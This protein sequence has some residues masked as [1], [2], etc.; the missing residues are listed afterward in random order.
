MRTA[1]AIGA[2]A[3]R[4]SSP[5]PSAD[6]CY[7]HAL[8]SS[9]TPPVLVRLLWL[10]IV[11]LVEVAALEAG[12]RLQG[13]SEASPGFQS[14]FMDD[15]AVGHRLRPNAQ[16]RYTTVEFSTDLHVNA[17]GVRDDQDIGPKAA[18]ERRVVVLGDSLVLSIQV[19]LAET[20]EKT[21]E[22]RLNAA[23]PSHRWR[24]INAGVQG[25]SPIDEYFFYEHVAAAFQPDVVLVVAFVGNDAAESAD[26]ESWLAVGHPPA[27]S[28]GASALGWAR[29]LSR[30][31]MVLQIVRIRLD[32]LKSRLATAA[33]ERPLTSYLKDPPA[34]VMHGFDVASRAFG[35]VAARAAADGAKTGL[36]LMPARFQ[37]DDGDY[38]RLAEAVRASGGVLER[39]AATDRFK[40]AVAPLGLPTLDVL[41]ILAAQPDRTGL[42]FQRNVHLTPRGHQVVGDALFAFM[43]SS[44]LA[45]LPRR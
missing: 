3:W 34:D 36:V 23:D 43:T 30:S 13:S 29:R 9:R 22:A 38:G 15:A 5:L 7:H 18:D 28:G 33:P 8:L 45:F 31:S 25:Y 40:A 17:Q 19:P 20:F 6:A 16:T 32:L 27:A 37:T 39:D 26:R 11:G 35:L 4:N 10:V 2:F 14:L 21:L 44:G 41:P 24:V 42:F 12:L 1:R